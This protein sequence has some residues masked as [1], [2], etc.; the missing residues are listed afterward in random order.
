MKIG[1]HV[2]ILEREGGGKKEERRREVKRLR[3]SATGKGE[4]TSSETRNHSTLRCYSTSNHNSV[5]KV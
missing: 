1:I 4:T 2:Q 3:P 5:H